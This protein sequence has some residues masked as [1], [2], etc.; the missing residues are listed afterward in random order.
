MERL[1]EITTIPI[2]VQMTVNHARLDY[3][4]STVD[5]EVSRDKGGIKIQSRPIRLQLDTFEARNSVCPTAMRSIEQA[6]QKG[7][8]KVY[9][10]MATYARRVICCWKLKLV[11]S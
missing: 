2:E 8:Q 3:K 7:S 6:A 5:L 9:D 10:T 1:I 11:N 4:R